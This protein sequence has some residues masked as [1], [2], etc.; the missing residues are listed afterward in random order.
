MGYKC[1]I[2]MQDFGH[3]KKAW[4]LHCT[5]A[6]YGAG[7]DAVNMV[8]H[9]VEGETMD[10]RNNSNPWHRTQQCP[11]CGS[12][13]LEVTAEHGPDGYNG[14]KCLDCGCSFGN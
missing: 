4:E 5:N 9:S 11:Q 13:H 12:T 2:C 8:I 14:Y 10:I 3:D 6:H 7:R 1:P